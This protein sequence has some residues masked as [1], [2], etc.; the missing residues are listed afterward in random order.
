MSQLRLTSQQKHVLW[1]ALP[2]LRLIPGRHTTSPSDSPYKLRQ[3][4]VAPWPEFLN[5]VLE[6]VKKLGDPPQGFRP[7]VPN[8]YHTIGNEHGLQGRYAQHVGNVLGPI[9]EE[10]NLNVCMADDQ[11]GLHVNTASGQEAIDMGMRQ[12]R[13][14]RRRY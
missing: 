6:S 12:N 8:E 1:S 13:G 7:Q 5:E 14:Q 9:F 11:A 3:D 10:L 4:Q 2:T